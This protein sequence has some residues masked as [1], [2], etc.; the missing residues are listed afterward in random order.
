[1]SRHEQTCKCTHTDTHTDRYYETESVE[2]EAKSDSKICHLLR[3]SKE[4]K[5]SASSI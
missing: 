3:L 1:M 2:T 5:I 4:Y